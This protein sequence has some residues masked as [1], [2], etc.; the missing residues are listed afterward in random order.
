MT[1][2]SLRG[3]KRLRPTR[4]WCP[5]DDERSRST[6]HVVRADD[7]KKSDVEVIY[8]TAPQGHGGEV[9]VKELAVLQFSSS[10]GCRTHAGA[11]ALAER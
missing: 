2:I 10:R 4:T 9:A 5:S 8:I 6:G 3:G 11:V 7:R 1:V